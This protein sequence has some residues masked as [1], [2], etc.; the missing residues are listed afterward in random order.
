MEVLCEYDSKSK[1]GTGSPESLR[2][3]KGTLHW[4]SSKESHKISVRMYD[5]LFMKE[6]PGSNPGGLYARP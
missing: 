1:S 2:K 6:S 3:V 4:V 5:R